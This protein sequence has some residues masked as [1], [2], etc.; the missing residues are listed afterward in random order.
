M[1]D[2]YADI[3]PIPLGPRQPM[4][5]QDAF[6]GGASS[7]GMSPQALRQMLAQMMA[8]GGPPFVS[9]KQGLA[10]SPMSRELMNAPG[11]KWRNATVRYDDT[12]Y[13]S[14]THADAMH[15]ML[16]DYPDAVDA[17][18]ADP[19]RYMG[20]LTHLPTSKAW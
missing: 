15:K 1:A 7:G 10:L 2:P 20:F 4:A 12:N 11:G 3:Q 18:N 14:S 16:Q 8:K 17:V 6:G 13:T 19:E 5:L 9:L